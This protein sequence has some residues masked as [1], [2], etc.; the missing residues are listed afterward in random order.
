[1][2]GTRWFTDNPFIRERREATF[3]PRYIVLA[4]AFYALATAVQVRTLAMPNESLRMLGVSDPY[5][6]LIQAVYLQQ[7]MALAA[8]TGALVPLLTAIYVFREHSRNR[9][10]YVQLT[11]IPRWAIVFGLLARDLL[12]LSLFYVL[13][14]A[15]GLVGVL[16]GSLTLWL[17]G[18]LSITLLLSALFGSAM[19]AAIALF[20]ERSL[21]F[22]TLTVLLVAGGA[23]WTEQILQNLVAA[24]IDQR[25]VTLDAIDSALIGEIQRLE[26]DDR[27][28]I[29][30]YLE[31]GISTS[32]N[33][34]RIETI[35]K[36][37]LARVRPLLLLSESEWS[38]AKSAM[39][40]KWLRVLYPWWHFS[41]RGWASELPHESVRQM[42]RNYE[43]E[44]QWWAALERATEPKGHAGAAEPFLIME[45]P[46]FSKRGRY[47]D[48]VRL[49]LYTPRRVQR[50]YQSYQRQALAAEDLHQAGSAILLYDLLKS[51]WPQH[52]PKI[53]ASVLMRDLEGRFPIVV[54]R[55]LDS[56]DSYLGVHVTLNER[57]EETARLVLSRLREVGT[58]GE[59]TY[60]FNCYQ[61]DP[62]RDELQEQLLQLMTRLRPDVK[63]GMSLTQQFYSEE[64]RDYLHPADVRL[65]AGHVEFAPP[66]NEDRGSEPDLS[67]VASNWAF[68]LLFTILFWRWITQNLFGKWPRYLNPSTATAIVV[69]ASFELAVIA[70]YAELYVGAIMPVAALVLFLHN[71]SQFGFEWHR[72]RIYG[73]LYNVLL[74]AMLFAAALALEMPVRLKTMSLLPIWVKEKQLWVQICV[75]LLVFEVIH[76]ISAGFL[77]KIVAGVIAI[78]AGVTM[79]ILLDSYTKIALVCLYTLA[80]LQFGVVIAFLTRIFVRRWR[81]PTIS[82]Q[83]LAV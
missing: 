3:R 9:L 50:Y 18:V 55:A 6:I 42:C 15:L 41:V 58:T 60:V 11:P 20:F 59:L 24:R 54:A 33:T 8:V 74:A 46:E 13:H 75:G 66:W 77:R 19:G 47:T 31:S 2:A 40:M 26:T 72:P 12:T 65:M 7:G 71:K 80:A 27:E 28:L 10:A 64:I 73:I 51:P 63:T 68:K 5:R 38:V 61:F 29:E 53:P 82:G 43:N 34:V 16:F 83:R 57:L 17:V 36:T 32:L 37:L 81:A 62:C 78:V 70:P 14:V 76:Q 45:R 23:L 22:V 69:L 39:D 30:H 67:T 56:L 4:F 44:R 49:I 52:L 21:A 48:Q 1:M 79:V 35:R 25:G